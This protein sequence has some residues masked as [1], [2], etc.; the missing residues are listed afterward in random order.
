[1]FPIR[2]F[3]D[4]FTFKE[5]CNSFA[6][7]PFNIIALYKSEHEEFRK[8]I[9][10]QF[11]RIHHQTQN[12]SFILCDEPPDGWRERPDAYYYRQ[13]VGEEYHP[14][15]ND[16]EIDIICRY[17]DIPTETLPCVVCFQDL[18]KY[19]FNCFSFR[20]I[21][22]YRIDRFFNS[23]LEKTAMFT[24]QNMDF[25]STMIQLRR[26][27][28]DC[29]IKI[30]WD[31]ANI[32]ENRLANAGNDIQNYRFQKR[33][34]SISP[35]DNETYTIIL[36]KIRKNYLSKHKQALSASGCMAAIERH[37]TVI[38]FRCGNTQCKKE[39]DLSIFTEVVLLW[40][41]IYLVSEDD[42]EAV[43]GLTC[44][45]C[46]K[47]IL[48]KCHA[49][50]AALLHVKIQQQIKA[51]TN[52][53]HQINK[54]AY[55][56]SEILKESGLIKHTYQIDVKDGEKQFV[57]PKNISC[58]KH[59]AIA[60]S[61]LPSLCDIENNHHFRAIPRV[62]AYYNELDGILE[63][64]ES[65][66]LNAFIIND[67]IKHNN[68]HWNNNLSAQFKHMITNDLTEQEYNG[69][70]LDK[71]VFREKQFEDNIKNFVDTAYIV[72]NCIDYEVISRDYVINWY[73][74]KIYTFS[75]DS[76]FQMNAKYSPQSDYH[77]QYNETNPHVISVSEAHNQ[78]IQEHI[79]NKT[80]EP[81]VDQP[82]NY[83]E[84]LNEQNNKLLKEMDNAFSKEGDVWIVKFKGKTT[85]IKHNKRMFYLIHLVNTPDQG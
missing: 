43:I 24:Y 14:Q 1:M 81:S 19:S 35:Y 31:R 63:E 47:T 17:M 6:T 71:M 51:T 34:G 59:K 74:R 3:S 80:A 55:Y 4:I 60:E 37:E 2:N 77:E 18:T 8:Y 67:L 61:S 26:E 84:F 50:V 25:I 29:S 78:L 68:K 64:K 48:K 82:S 38:P 9:L 12:I 65:G 79:Q 40:G 57:M 52:S 44:P 54:S 58:Q 56:S 45:H 11:N 23:M 85:T 70:Y 16:F 15:L 69:L 72:R 33:K 21:N 75:E 66:E 76:K 22:Q 73:A 13:L 27:F 46:Y 32:I 83:D 7:T 53:N 41:F 49:D 62:V 20:S 28:P 39:Y 42:E 30:D 5:N 36:P 10:N